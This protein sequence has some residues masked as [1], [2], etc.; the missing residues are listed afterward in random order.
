MPPPGGEPLRVTAAEARRGAERVGVVDDAAPHVGDGLEPA[1]R[2][3]REARHL[4]AVVHPPAVDAGEV[5]AQ[6][7]P[8]E[9][10]VGPE[11]PVARR[12][13]VV[14][15]HAEQE[16]VDRRP[17][18]PRQ[19][20]RLQHD[21]LGHDLVHLSVQPARARPGFPG[22]RSRLYRPGR[23]RCTRARRAWRQHSPAA[24]DCFD[25]IEALAAGR[26][27][28]RG[29]RPGAGGGGRGPRHPEELDRTPVAVAD[30]PTTRAPACA[31]RSPSSSWSTCR[32]PPTSSAPRSAPRW[33]PT[34]S[35]S[36]RPS[37]WSTCSNAAASRSNGSSPTPVR[38]GRRTDDR[39]PL[40][41]AR[42]VHARSSRS[43]PRSTRSPPSSCASAAPVRT[44]AASASRASACEAVESAGDEALFAAD[45]DDAALTERQR[46]ALALADA[47]IW[48]PTAIDDDAR[49]ARA[50][51]SCPT[52]RSSRSSSTSCATPPTRSRC[53]SAATR[54]W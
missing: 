30:E 18:A 52:P 19:R 27:G 5:G 22:P 46:A 50:R 4:G 31:S 40:G 29:A 47:V 54:P 53:R 10:R 41:H 21:L 36:C 43:T 11:A 3:L 16:R 23:D 14:V 39:R 42:G 7:P 26:G 20:H 28:T 34:P 33:A 25:R 45:A 51:A 37:T 2:V 24:F 35:P 48:Q 49:R 13:G 12:V 44:T 8:R 15:V 32:A 6:L 17:G 1:V 38:S 9:R